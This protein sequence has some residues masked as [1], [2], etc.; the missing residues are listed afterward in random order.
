LFHS[1]I[2]NPTDPALINSTLLI[3]VKKK[4]EKGKKG[5]GQ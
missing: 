1:L 5:L 4:Q 3:R 2:H